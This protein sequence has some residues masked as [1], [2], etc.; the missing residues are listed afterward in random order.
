M[1]KRIT[2]LLL[3]CTVLLL[4]TQIQ[5]TNFVSANFMEI[6]PYITINNDGTLTPETAYINR[7]GDVYSLTSSMNCAYAIVINCSSIIFDGGNHTIKGAVNPAQGYVNIGLELTHITNVT[8]QNLKIYGFGLGDIRLNGSNCSFLNVTTTYASLRCNY[9][10]FEGCNFRSGIDGSKASS[11]VSIIGENNTFTR[12][13]FEGICGFTGDNFLDDGSVGNYWSSYK[14]ND[15]N[16][17]GIGDTPY[18]VLGNQQDNYPIM[19]PYLAPISPK[20]IVTPTVQPVNPNSIQNDV[21]ITI[22]ASV[23][24][25][26]L[27]GISLTIA[28][29]KS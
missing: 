11:Q 5:L 28:K 22:I 7:N 10:S 16:H 2:L 8:I 14:G 19:K 13:N 25:A 4:A 23:T 29:R 24:I 12:N 15:T 21:L 6:L 9:S 17:D 3:G 18:S 20:P 26:L 1:T 27:V